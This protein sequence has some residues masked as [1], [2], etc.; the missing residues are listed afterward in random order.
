MKKGTGIFIALL[1]A[2]AGATA[3]IFAI[4][5]RNEL[6]EYDYDEFDDEY[7]DECDCE[8]CDCCEESDDEEYKP[9]AI[10]DE[11]VALDSIEEE[12]EDNDM[13]ISS[14]F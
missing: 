12:I 1:A 7:F 13:P 3:A 6:E 9:E 5:K 2:A 4:K 8:E 10:Y 14:D 11:E